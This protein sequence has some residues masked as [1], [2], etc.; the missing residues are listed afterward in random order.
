MLFL[1]INWLSGFYL[2][3]SKGRM[4]SGLTMRHVISFSRAKHFEG[5]LPFQAKFANSQMKSVNVEVWRRLWGMCMSVIS[6]IY[7][8][9]IWNVNIHVSW[10]F[11]AK[12]LF[13]VINPE[14]IFF[15]FKLVFFHILFLYFDS[16]D[17]NQLNFAVLVYFQG[18]FLI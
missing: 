8:C 12:R 9:S 3:I 18:T 5:K 1:R 16:L 10:I 15:L 6:I 13:F 17:S 2:F 11:R 4:L 14:W 7:V